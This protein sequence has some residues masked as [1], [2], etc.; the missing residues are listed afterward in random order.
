MP[1]FIF[2]TVTIVFKSH[3]W[4]KKQKMCAIRQKNV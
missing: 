1:G 3:C 4:V 2:Y